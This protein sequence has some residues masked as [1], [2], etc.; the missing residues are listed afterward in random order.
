MKVFVVS[1]MGG[2]E[3]YGDENWDDIIGARTT[4]E[5]AKEFIESH[6]QKEWQDYLDKTT[7]LGLSRSIHTHEQY[8]TT[9]LDNFKI[10]ELEILE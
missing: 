5:S 4:K 9:Q 10:T 2:C 8:K 1:R 6:L 7:A 3:D